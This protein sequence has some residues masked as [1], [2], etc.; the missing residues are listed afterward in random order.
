MDEYELYKSGMSLPD[1]FKKTGIPLSTLRFRFKKAGILRNRIEAIR[2]AAKDG[3][4]GTGMLGKKRKFTDEH[5]NNISKG[6]AGKGKG[7]RITASGYREF[8]MGEHKGRLEHVVIMESKIGRKLKRNECVHHIDHN[9]LNNDIDNLQLM[10]ISDHA[11]LHRKHE[12]KNGK[13][14]KRNKYGQWY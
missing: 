11:A 4:L 12:I 10:T 5:K 7:Y 2:M 9:K 3:K 1:V 14:R 8:T 13:N 6:R